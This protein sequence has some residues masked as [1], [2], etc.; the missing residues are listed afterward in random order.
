[1][2]ILKEVE[3]FV[4]NYYEEKFSNQLSYHSIEHT[5]LVVN[6]SKKIAEFENLD[7]KN[8][9]VLL[10]AAWFHD[11][12]HAVSHTDHEE[13]SCSIA[14][15]F[16]VEKKLDEELITGVE[17]TIRSTKMG[18][19]KNTLIEKII[20]DADHAH[21]GLENF[22]EISNLLRKEVCSLFNKKCSKLEYWI[23]TL[24][25][26]KKVEFLTTYAKNNMDEIKN[27]NIEKVEKRIR[28]LQ[29]Q[30]ENGIKNNKTTARGIETMFRLTAR[31]QINLSSIADN[32]ANI[33]LTINAVIVSVLVSTG[34][35]IFTN[36][37]YNIMVPGLILVIGCLISLV[38]AILSV[39]PKFGTGNYSDE[40]LR[41]RK[42]N[43]LFFGNIYKMPYSKYENGIKDMMDDYDY[44]Y[45]SLT[46]DQYNLGKVLAQKYRLLRYSYNFFMV[47]FVVAVLTFLIMNVV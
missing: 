2:E 46:K 13:E 20:Y 28:K 37:G 4:T 5:K 21:T 34:A 43:L 42:I 22:M 15:N 18:A 16:L 36:N 44:L 29:N 19:A 6:V 41:D 31:N 1:M 35:L 33:M 26:L 3:I 45:G 7:T 10:I 8:K 40:D 23:D 32:K 9:Q 24:K 11:I 17:K 25:F 30:K 38:F 47:S 27:Q 12:G 14:R 39:R